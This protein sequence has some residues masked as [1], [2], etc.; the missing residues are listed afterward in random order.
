MSIRIGRGRQH[1]V[2]LARQSIGDVSRYHYILADLA[3]Q[4]LDGLSHKVLTPLKKP[5]KKELPAF[6]KQIRP[7]AKAYFLMISSMRKHL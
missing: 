2:S 5:R 3:Y 4:G 6:A 1:D 7:L